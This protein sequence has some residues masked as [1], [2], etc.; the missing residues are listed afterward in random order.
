MD[1]SKLKR[2]W[3]AEENAVL[4]GWDF[5]RLNDKTETAPMKWDYVE[6]VKRYLKPTDA[7]LDMGTGGG[8]RLLEIGH[9][10]HLTHVTEGYPPN[11]EL[12]HKNLAPLGVGVNQVFSNVLP[13]EN[14]IFDAVINRHSVF[15]MYE[16]WRVLKP[17]G[18]FITQQVGADNNDRLI[19]ALGYEKHFKFHTLQNNVEKVA[20]QGFDVVLQDECLQTI[21][22]NDVSAVVFFAKSI[23]WQFPG[24]SVETHLP[25]LVEIQKQVDSNGYFEDVNHRFIIVA[26]RN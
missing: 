23:P 5:S 10:Y 17:G 18:L 22:Y 24:F 21:K 20:M 9:P 3:L 8:E 13:F 1:I 2:Q 16:V 15:D 25:Q 11:V 4:T 7:L 26:R 19:A 6:L 14:G 12:C